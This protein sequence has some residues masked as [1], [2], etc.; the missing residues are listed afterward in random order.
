MPSINIH[1]TT[2]PNLRSQDLRAGRFFTVFFLFSST[3]DDNPPFNGT[4]IAQFA[5]FECAS[6]RKA[7]CRGLTSQNLPWYKVTQLDITKAL[8]DISRRQAMIFREPVGGVNR[9]Q[10]PLN[11]SL[12]LSGGTSSTNGLAQ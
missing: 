6:V 9:Q 12:E 7:D 2:E 8:K 1:L 10:A 5:D 4:I 11:Y 3:I